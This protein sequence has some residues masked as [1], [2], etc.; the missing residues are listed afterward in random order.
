MDFSYIRDI[1][2]RILMEKRLTR[3]T[4]DKMIAGVCGGLA[5][6]FNL[7]PTLVRLGFAFGT[8]LT[9]AFGGIVA[10]I[11]CIV[12]IPEEGRQY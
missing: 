5:N 3:S 6:Y 1:I 7:D 10:Y 9:A 2:Q 8:L 11:I 12:V 4:T